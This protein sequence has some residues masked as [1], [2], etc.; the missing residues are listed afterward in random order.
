MEGEGFVTL[1]VGHSLLL[2]GA[3]GIGDRLDVV[4]RLVEVRRASGT[5]HHQM[6]RSHGRLVVDD[7]ARGA[8][9][10]L[11]RRPRS[12][13]GPLRDALLAGDGG[14]GAADARLE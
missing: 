5:W 14:R 13:P 1:V 8:F 9:F 11:G 10:T 2:P 6:L 3:A 4:S 12:I 7:R